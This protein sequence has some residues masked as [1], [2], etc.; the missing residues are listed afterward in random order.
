MAI[1]TLLS[2]LYFGLLSSDIYVSESRYVV[3]SPNKKTP[4]SGIGAMLGSAGFSGFSR[5]Q[6]NVHT[7]SEYVRSRDV[8]EQLDQ[9][10]RLADSWSQIL[11]KTATE[12]KSVTYNSEFNRL[13]FSEL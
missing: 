2:I 7:I 3:R 4:S 8:L 13:I 11:E 1:P 10:L 6:D 5:A 12:F 9:K